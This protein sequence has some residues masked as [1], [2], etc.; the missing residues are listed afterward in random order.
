MR[1]RSG[2]TRSDPPDPYV[3]A[4]GA[5]SR[6]ELTTRQMRERLL[7]RGC[8][9]ADVDAALDRLQREG[10]LDDQ[11]AAR[12]FSRTEVHVKRRGP[13]RIRRALEAMGIDRDA[14]RQALD[15]GFADQSVDDVLQAALQRKLRGPIVDEKH[16]Q[17]L[18]GYLVRQGFDVSAAAAAVRARRRA[19]DA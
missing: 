3:Y 7:R 13:E 6:R 8:A 2:Q 11:R 16:A 19:Q 12:A 17:R 5:L 9:P 18:V 1:A 4:L 10:A 15:E 14:A